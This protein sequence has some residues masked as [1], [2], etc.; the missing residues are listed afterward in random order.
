[1]PNAF[2]IRP[3]LAELELSLGCCCFVVVML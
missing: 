2:L 3:L 1:L